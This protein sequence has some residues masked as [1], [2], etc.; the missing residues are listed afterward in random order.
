MAGARGIR[1]KKFSVLSLRFEVRKGL[2]SLTTQMNIHEIQMM[3]D[4]L[5]DIKCKDRTSDD[6]GQSGCKKIRTGR[7]GS[8]IRERC[9]KIRTGYQR[10]WTGS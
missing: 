9:E 2:E 4:K 8:Q 5:K 3:S 10:S 6:C 7:Q 1:G